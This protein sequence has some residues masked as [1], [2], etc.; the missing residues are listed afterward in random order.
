LSAVL[1]LA[2]VGIGGGMWWNHRKV[3]QEKN[4]LEVK[5]KKQQESL[6]NEKNLWANVEK[7]A[8]PAIVHIRCQWRVRIPRR[9]SAAFSQGEV[10]FVGGVQG[11]GVL[12]R[13]GLILTAK[14]VAEPWKLRFADWDEAVK[15]YDAKAEYDLLDVQFPGQQPLHASLVATAEQ[16]DLAL[17]QVQTTAAGA[18]PIVKSNADVRVTDRMAVLG[19]PADLGQKPV[20]MKNFSGFGAEWTQIT[21][22]TPTFVIGT[23]SQPMSSAPNFVFFDASV[24]HGN[25]GGAVINERGELIG[26]VSQKF[27]RKGVIELFGQEI[28][29]QEPVEAGNMAVSP[30]DIQTFLRNRG[31]G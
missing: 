12:I 31:L 26:V 24:T 5:L 3:Q 19:Y 4:A 6:E 22:V 20:L 29:I 10:L 25:S 21:Q 23:V 2:V 28:P 16:Q 17:L 8:S 13:P 7:R 15:L 1:L 14:H 18:V 27:Q 11:S 9:S 30:D